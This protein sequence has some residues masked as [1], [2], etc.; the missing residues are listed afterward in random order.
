M[1]GLFKRA[2]ISH[3]VLIVA[4]IPLVFMVAFAG[5]L[6]VDRFATLRELN[7]LS[8]LTWLAPQISGVVH[9][10]QKERGMSAGFIASKGRTFAAELPGQRQN[11]DA[12][13][14]LM[15]E[16]LATIDAAAHGPV[17]SQRVADAVAALDEIAAQRGQIDAGNYTVADMAGYYTGTITKLLAVVEQT[18]NLTTET[19]VSRQLTAYTAYLQMKERAGIERAMGSAGYSAGAFAPAIYQRFIKLIAAQETFLKVFLDYATPEDIAFHDETVHGTAV[20]EVQRLRDIALATPDQLQ[21][22][23]GPYWFATITQK[24]D[25]F[26]AVE[27]F[28]AGNLLVIEDDI[29]AAARNSLFIAIVASLAAFAATIGTMAVIVR[30]IS[31]PINGLT[32]VMDAL[33]NDDQSVEIIG[34]GRGDEIGSMA[35]SVQVFKDNAQEMAR[36]RDEQQ[37]AEQRTTDEKRAAANKLADDVE[38][39]IGSIVA[40]VSSAAENLQSTAQVLSGNA[41]SA[42]GQATAVAAAAE[43]ASANV[44]TVASASEEMTSSIGEINTQITRSSQVTSQAVEQAGNTS[45]TVETLAEAA[46]R[47][48][49]VVSLINDIAEQTN[50]LALNATIEAARAGEAGKGFAVVAA[51][52]KSLANQTA[53]ATEEIS[54]QIATMQTVTDRT[55]SDISEISKVIAEVDEI[56]AAIAAAMEEQ[57]SVTSEIA[58]NVHEAAKGTQEVSHN[59]AGVTQSASESGDAAGNLLTASQELADQSGR[60]KQELARVVNEIRAA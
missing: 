2:R 11:T 51:E 45:A 57:G 44:A 46:Q 41:E 48:G 37:A 13:H 58:R 30:S 49:D 28:V 34:T 43:Q 52:V 38:R 9:E 21:G 1:F 36:L 20:I 12:A 60:L 50:L 16:S 14:D 6:S 27:D 42:S 35:R 55:V 47:I 29:K 40:A 7:A 10:M 31:Q 18:A 39:D 54:G 32:G 59:I 25:L 22:I 24:I 8:K 56:A 33:A 23:E 17:L 3:R 4:T 15:A 53:K 19:E 26:K 5:T